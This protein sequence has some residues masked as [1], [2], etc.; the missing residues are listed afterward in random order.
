MKK[1]T[2]DSSKCIGCGTCVAL[3]QKSFKMADNSKAQPINPPRD[4]KEV[5]QNAIDSCPVAAI[6]WKEE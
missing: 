2:V 4:D 3:A 1:L 5:V 6:S